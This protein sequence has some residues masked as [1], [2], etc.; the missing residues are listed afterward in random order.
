M[1]VGL[2]VQIERERDLYKSQSNPT[3]KGRNLS[4][5]FLHYPWAVS[6]LC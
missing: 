6:R 3:E 5:P 4:T 2:L 1:F